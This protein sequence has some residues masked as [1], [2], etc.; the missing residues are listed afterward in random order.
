[1]SK[2]DKSQRD[3]PRI[4]IADDDHNF[5]EMLELALKRAGM[6]IVAT[7][8]D[9]EQAVETTI[10]SKPDC[11]LLDIAMPL[12]DGLAALTNIKFLSPQTHIVVVT[13]LKDPNCRT[14]AMELGANAF[15]L[16]GDNLVEDLISIIMTLV[17][18]EGP[19]SPMKP[20]SKPIFPT[21]PNIRLVVEE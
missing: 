5:T 13:A 1:M 4:V 11:L 20:S 14:R 16:K 19:P 21:T 10:E 17:S 3:T 18:E 15:F 6:S 9:G 7:A 8:F 12:M 2:V